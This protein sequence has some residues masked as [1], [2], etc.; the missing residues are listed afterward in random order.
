MHYIFKK[1]G[2]F[3]NIIIVLNLSEKQNVMKFQ[4]NKKYA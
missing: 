3:I 4:E 2:Y 1:M